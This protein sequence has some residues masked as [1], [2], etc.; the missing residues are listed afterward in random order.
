MKT[1]QSTSF[2][3]APG[4]QGLLRTNGVL[5]EHMPLAIQ[6]D[7]ACSELIGKE[8]F[9][10]VNVQLKTRVPVR[11]EEP[12]VLRRRLEGRSGFTESLLLRANGCVG[13]VIRINTP[14]YVTR[15]FP[16]GEI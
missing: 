1:E 10:C 16:R 14:A 13:Y 3:T 2:E 5:P 7:K 8:F 12:P 9:Y 4:K 15:E 6:F 11:P